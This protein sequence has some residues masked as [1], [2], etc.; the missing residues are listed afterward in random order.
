M[1]TPAS[2]PVTRYDVVTC[3]EVVEHVPDV[4]VFLRSVAA[5]AKP[6]GHVIVSTIN[7]TAASF[8]IAKVGAEYVAGVVP[9]GAH[10]WRRFVTPD[11][12]TAAMRKAG[13]LEIHR[14]R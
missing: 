6:G 3:L 9:I 2:P 4:V 1:H 14:D 12:L 10:E 11:E 13:K 8:A 5:L 7:R